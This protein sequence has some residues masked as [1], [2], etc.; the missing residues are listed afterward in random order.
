MSSFKN[1]Y[2]DYS[3]YSELI[4]QK[5]NIFYDSRIG[6]RFLTGHHI[7]LKYNKINEKNI[8]IIHRFRM[9]DIIRNCISDANNIMN[10]K[11][12]KIPKVIVKSLYSR[13]IT[14][15]PYHL[16]YILFEIIKNSMEAVIKYENAIC[17][18]INIKCIYNV[19]GLTLHIF[20][21]GGG[22][23]YED[24]NKIFSF[25]YTTN[26][27]S[28]YEIDMV[29]ISGFGHGLGISKLYIEYFGGS[30]DILPLENYGTHTI[31]NIKSLNTNLKSKADLKY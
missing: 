20:D 10:Q 8:G 3:K 24:K 31:I 11:Y 27:L 21:Q 30:I 2:K 15:I 22:F 26:D 12:N 19:Q 1:R 23:N 28:D 6:I 29:P 14:H 13:E 25:L 18:D 4:D 9:E 17:P 16:H 5:L 7:A